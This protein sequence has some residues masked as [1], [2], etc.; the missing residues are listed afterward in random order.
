MPER[1]TDNSKY[2]RENPFDVPEGYFDMVEYR[3]EERIRAE[4]SEST[5]GQKFIRMVKPILGLAASFALAFLLIYYPI[6]KILSKYTAGT[7]GQ[8][9]EKTKLDEEFLT[10]YGYL[11]ENTFFLALTSKEE[12]A[13]FESD[14]VLSF[15]T[16]ELD[17]YEV[18][19]EIIN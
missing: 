5:R 18:Y 10:D 4:E 3:I 19:A 12:P 15:L 1:M 9:S 17:D 13:D 6:T 2:S 11:D 16:S 7:T 14:E 8:Q